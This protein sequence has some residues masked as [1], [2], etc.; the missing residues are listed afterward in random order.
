MEKTPI[1]TILGLTL[2]TVPAI[3]SVP[4]ITANGDPPSVWLPEEKLLA[5]TPGAQLGTELDVS[6]NTAVVAAPGIDQVLVYER[7]LSGWE[8]V[9]RLSS[10]E[11]G[12]EFGSSVAIHQ[13]TIVVGARLADTASV[14]SPGA[15]YVF[16]ER[17]QGWQESVKITAEDA[18][19]LDVFGQAVTVHADTIAIGAVG[20]DTGGDEDAGAVYVYQESPEGWS[21]QAKLVS[22]DP[23]PGD[24]LGQAVDLREDVI[25]AGTWGPNEVH[26]F[27]ETDGGWEAATVV[28]GPSTFGQSVAVDGT[29]VAAAAPLED[30]VHIYNKAGSEGWRQLAKLTPSDSAPLDAPSRFGASL[31]LAESSKLLLIGAPM[32]DRSPAPPG[33]LPLASTPCM[34]AGVTTTC[35]SAGAAYV[36]QPSSP[37]AWTHRSK[38]VP[39]DGT[40]S[41][42]FG[43]SVGLTE[44]SA[45][46]GA[47][48]RRVLPGVESGTAYVFSPSHEAI[49]GGS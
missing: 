29:T 28:T 42:R 24:N 23:S 15:A 26:I 21:Q 37:E 5:P 32:D 17:A 35:D 39:P 9:T 47:P 43:T 8:E 30:Q 20:A 16:E 27:E 33:L 19:Q 44:D 10:H 14:H 45:I 38:I 46:V 3:A 48:E 49:P 18:R 25:A 1:T 34:G 13:D 6:G 12:D 22:Q 11:D 40:P 4:S 36:Y 41:D 2:L 31:S 7:R